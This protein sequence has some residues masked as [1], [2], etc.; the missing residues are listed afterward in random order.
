MYTKKET[1]RSLIYNLSVEEINNPYLLIAQFFDLR[2]LEGHLDFLDQWKEYVLTD[3]PCL[4]NHCPA[5]LLQEYQHVNKLLEAAWLLRKEN[6]FNFRLQ[7]NFREQMKGKH[8]EKTRDCSDL[9][10]EEI[11]NPYLVF[12]RLFKSDSLEAYRIRLLDWLNEALNTETSGKAYEQ[13]ASFYK[14]LRRL[15][16]ATWLV[17][18]I[19]SP[20]LLPAENIKTDQ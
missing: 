9:M 11:L 14:N 1:K 7:A 17:H 13:T 16:L 8:D 19:G 12:R 18:Q 20:I 2:D 10:E 4:T 6:K 15:F 5:N 3:Q